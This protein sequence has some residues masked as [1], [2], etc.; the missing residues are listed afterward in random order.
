MFVLAILQFEEKWKN[1]APRAPT[2]MTLQ[3]V[4][5]AKSGRQ[6]SP[7]VL[8]FVAATAIARCADFRL[9]GGC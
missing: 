8:Y 6:V 5:L 4:M 9:R 1:V 3:V 7:A 2:T